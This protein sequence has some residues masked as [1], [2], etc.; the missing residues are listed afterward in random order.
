MIVPGIWDSEP[1]H[2]QSRWQDERAARDARVER[3]APSSWTEPDAPDWRDAIS[4]AVDASD[5]PPVLVAHSL[6]V[7]AVADWLVTESAVADRVAG[8]FLVAPP[9]PDA[10]SFPSAARG[11]TAPTGPAPVPTTL[12]VVSDDDP[13]CSPGRALAFAGTLGAEVRRIGPAGHVNVAAGV[14]SWPEGRRLLDGFAD[15]G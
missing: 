4:R 5:A 8:A 12:L 11:F 6:G 14:G 13:Y 10:E 15:R 3:I 9:D 7:L 2:W 1:E